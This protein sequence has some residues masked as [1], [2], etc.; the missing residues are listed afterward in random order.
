MRPSMAR[1][2]TFKFNMALSF[3]GKSDMPPNDHQSFLQMFHWADRTSSCS[4]G[5]KTSRGLSQ[6][7]NYSQ[8][9]AVRGFTQPNVPRKDRE[10]QL[11]QEYADHR[12]LGTEA[13]TPMGKKAEAME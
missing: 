3:S 2:I 12:N 7:L 5:D 13:S 1:D 11:F 4:N 8:D 10:N 6:T 9:T